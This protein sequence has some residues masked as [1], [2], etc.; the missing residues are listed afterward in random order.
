MVLYLSSRNLRSLLAASLYWC[1]KT[2]WSYCWRKRL[3]ICCSLWHKRLLR[4]PYWHICWPNLLWYWRQK[5]RNAIRSLL[6]KIQTSWLRLFR[7]RYT[8]WKNIEIIKL[9]FLHITNNST[10]K[11]M[12]RLHSSWNKRRWNCKRYMWSISSMP[13]WWKLQAILQRTWV[14]R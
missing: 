13:F 1:R 10:L 6:S 9:L 3:Q 5:K 7:K 2:A 4:I 12:C 11:I 14:S 8:K